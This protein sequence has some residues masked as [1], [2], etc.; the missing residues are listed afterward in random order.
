MN[1][2]SVSNGI[3]LQFLFLDRIYRINGIFFRL[4][5]KTFG[6]KARLFEK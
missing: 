4:R 2:S 3:D 6:P 1:G 5:R